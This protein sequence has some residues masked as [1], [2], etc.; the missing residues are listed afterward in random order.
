[1]SFGK[2]YHS[3]RHKLVWHTSECCIVRYNSLAWILLAPTSHVDDEYARAG[4]FDPKI[5]ITTSRDP[6][7]RLQQFAKVIGWRGW[8]FVLGMLLIVYPRKCVWYSLTRNVSTVVVTL[9][10]TLWKHVE[11][12]R[13]QIWWSCMNIVVS[14]VSVQEKTR[15]R[16]GH[17]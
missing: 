1:M 8:H 14:L 15:G 3:I 6:S 9:S 2:T 13:W 5:M 17:Y 16:N 10:R 7:S 12:T 4:I 11:Q